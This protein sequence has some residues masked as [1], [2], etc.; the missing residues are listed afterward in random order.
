MKTLVEMSPESFD[1][2]LGMCKASDREYAIMKNGLIT[3]YGEKNDS[4]RTVV[5][6][7]DAA[8]AK[9]IVALANRFLKG[10]AEAIRLYP[11]GD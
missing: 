3:P 8:E 2:L 1:Q 5:I 10:G 7:C 11:A 6:L 9:L 4:P